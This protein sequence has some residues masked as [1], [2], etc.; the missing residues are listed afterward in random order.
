MQERWNVRIRSAQRCRR[1]RYSRLLLLFC[2]LVVAR[3][4]SQQ[5]IIDT[6]AHILLPGQEFSLNPSVP[7]SP[8][9]L[10]RQMSEAGVTRAAI[11]S[12][13]PA[14]ALAVT[15]EHNDYVLQLSEQNPAFFAVA[16]VHPLDGQ[17]ALDEVARVAKR[18]AK[19]IKLHP[20]YQQFD[21]AD[22]Q[23]SAVVAAAGEHGLV[24][25]FD[26]I[27]AWDGEGVGKFV[28]LAVANP[29]TRIVLAHMGGTQFHQ[30]L[31][32]AV[33]AKG[34]F[35]KGNVYFDLSAI[36][37]L[38]SDS[39]RQEELIWTIRQIG[40]EQFLFATDFP[41]F[42]IKETLDIFQRYDLTDE[43]FQQIF[44]DNAVKVFGLQ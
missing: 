9:E 11:L 31:L 33:F 13:V 12:M 27:S 20:F 2:L 8:A 26:S 34:P 24:V 5:Q 18:G 3:A 44:H 30:M 14:R 22:P 42:D 15:R 43:E 38:Y 10:K 21:L 4:Y 6:H 40:V 7:G 41:V 37:E 23:V 28:N 25:L 36:I 29:Q 16:S 1:F 39:P 32:F 35:Y 17:Q 19:G